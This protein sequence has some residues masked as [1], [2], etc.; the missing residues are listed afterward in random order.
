MQPIF[1][2]QSMKIQSPGNYGLQQLKRANPCHRFTPSDLWLQ[3]NIQN[4][5]DTNS[6]QIAAMIGN[7]AILNQNYDITNSWRPRE[8]LISWSNRNFW[9]WFF[10][11]DIKKY[12]HPNLT[13]WTIF[14]IGFK[15]ETGYLTKYMNKA[16]LQMCKV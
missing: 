1:H 8:A 16:N 14:F 2:F 4:D 13:C 3:T 11:P 12:L 5:F 15:L 9:K 10:I 6:H 7:C